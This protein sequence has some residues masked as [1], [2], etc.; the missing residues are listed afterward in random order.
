MALLGHLS[1]RTRELVRLIGV[2]GFAVLAVVS[3]SCAALSGLDGYNA[4][5]DDC[6]VSTRDPSTVT[7]AAASTEASPREDAPTPTEDTSEPTVDASEGQLDE[8]SGPGDTGLDGPTSP[9]IGDAH[10]EDV[11]TPPVD[12]G[13]D[14]VAPIVDAGIG[15]GPT[16]GPLAT[17]HR[18]NANQV[19]CANLA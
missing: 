15:A 12:A 10:P 17:N 6:E 9:P 5:A 19:C 11:A 8:A 16:C 3:A 4:C 2:A 13:P 18:C 7:D 14:A 1:R